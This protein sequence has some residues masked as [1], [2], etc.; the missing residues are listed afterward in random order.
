MI[1]AKQGK[2]GTRDCL[3][4]NAR[5]V[6]SLVGFGVPFFDW[7]DSTVEKMGLVEEASYTTVIDGGTP[8]FLLPL[9][10][11]QKLL[12]PLDALAADLAIEAKRQPEKWNA[13]CDQLAE[14][15]ALQAKHFPEATQY[16]QRPPTVEPEPE[17]Q[18]VLSDTAQ[19]E[20]EAFPPPADP[21]PCPT[22]PEPSTEAVSKSSA[23][24]KAKRKAKTAKPGKVVA[25]VSLLSGRRIDPRQIEFKFD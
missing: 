18:P 9:E 11:A 15:Q 10:I 21:V 2:I 5:D 16:A 7:F 20:Q 4:V 1:D 14:M 17:H 12:A 13:V 25:I 8:E 22:Q 6:H 3:V 23:P 19:T 24:V